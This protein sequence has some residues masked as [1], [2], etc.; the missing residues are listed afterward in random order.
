MVEKDPCRRTTITI[1]SRY[2]YTFMGPTQRY[3]NE[4]IIR[5]KK[6]FTNTYYTCFLCRTQPPTR[7][8]LHLYRELYG[9][10]GVPLK[11]CFVEV[12]GASTFFS[13]ETVALPSV[14]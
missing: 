6:H 3:R 2:F 7:R 5:G 4:Y 14:L 8:E 13:Y 9:E 10:E 11:Y 12:T 1:H